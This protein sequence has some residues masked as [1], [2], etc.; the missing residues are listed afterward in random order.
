V[1]LTVTTALSAPPGEE[2]A[3]FIEDGNALQGFIGDIDVLLGIERYGHGPHDLT[4]AGA[5]AA[6]I[7]MILF[8]ERTHRHAFITHAPVD[9]RP[10][11]IQYIEHPV[12]ANGHI[13]GIVKPST[14]QPIKANGVAVTIEIVRAHVSYFPCLSSPLPPRLRRR[15]GHRLTCPLPR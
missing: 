10:G 5:T 8:G 3:L 4:I 11:P 6:K 9:V 14:P 7:A 2:S 1:K 13:D 12:P 15:R